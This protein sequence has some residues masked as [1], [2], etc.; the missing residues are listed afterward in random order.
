MNESDELVELTTVGST[1]EGQMLVELLMSG[2]IAAM[3]RDGSISG[4]GGISVNP[5]GG[6]GSLLV[7][8][9]HLADAQEFLRLY[10]VPLLEESDAAD[11]S[12]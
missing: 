12:D 6:A 5:S 4:Y 7:H 10:R 11:P 9:S 3:L 1:M 8:R 2:G